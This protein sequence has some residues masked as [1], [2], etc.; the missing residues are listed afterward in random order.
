MAARY[1]IGSLAEARA[2]LDDQVLGQR[3]REVT[4]IVAGLDETSPERVFGP[5]DAMKLHS[6]ATLFLRAAPAEQ[7][8]QDVL[9]RYFAGVADAQT[10]RLLTSSGT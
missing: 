6:S 3:L 4:Q 2:Y 1:A 10:D 8:F 7:L 9:D 5:I